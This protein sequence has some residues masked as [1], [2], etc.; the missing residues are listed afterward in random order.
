MGG[1]FNTKDNQ[2]HTLLTALISQFPSLSQIK[3]GT[4]TVE[5]AK[6][7]FAIQLKILDFLLVNNTDPNLGGAHFEQPPLTFLIAE[8]D[9]SYL[10]QPVVSI[11]KRFLDWNADVNKADQKG[12]RALHLAAWT[13]D[14]LA[15]K[16]LLANAAKINATCAKKWTAL[17]YAAARGHVEIVKML[18]QNGAD[19]RCINKEGDTALQLA[20]R[21]NTEPKFLEVEKSIA[22]YI[23]LTKGKTLPPLPE[24]THVYLDNPIV[25]YPNE[26]CVYH[27]RDPHNPSNETRLT[28]VGDAQD[29]EFYDISSSSYKKVNTPPDELVSYGSDTCCFIV[30][31]ALP[32]SL[33][34]K[35]F[36]PLFVYLYQTPG[37]IYASPA[38]EINLYGQYSFSFETQK[39]IKVLDDSTVGNYKQWTADVPISFGQYPIFLDDEKPS[40]DALRSIFQQFLKHNSLDKLKCQLET[41]VDRCQ[42][43]AFFASEF[44]K[45]NYGLSTK[46]AF[47]LWENSDWNAFYGHKQWGY[48]CAAMVDEWVFDPWLGS[49][50]GWTRLDQWLFR[51]EEPKPRRLLLT[52]PA[53]FSDLVYGRRADGLNLME[54]DPLI[55]ADLFKD[56]QFLCSEALPKDQETPLHSFLRPLQVSLVSEPPKV[57]Q[58]S[59]T[60]KLPMASLVFSFFTTKEKGRVAA[61]S[62]EF[63]QLA[64]GLADWNT[65]L[66]KEF[67]NVNDAQKAKDLFLSQPSSRLPEYLFY[68][69]VGRDYLEHHLLPNGADKGSKKERVE[70]LK[71]MHLKGVFEQ[72]LLAMDGLLNLGQFDLWVINERLLNEFGLYALRKGFVQSDDYLSGG[73]NIQ[74]IAYS[75]KLFTED[76]I[77]ALE[78]GLISLKGF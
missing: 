70:L 48:H 21:R 74:K 4:I 8:K 73:L 30:K 43:R 72:N 23:T 27:I 28:F 11:L 76:G 38:F 14:S 49:N 46:L 17:H 2:G 44:L 47:K 62:K 6:K 52:H 75:K 57:S 56:L 77:K 36:P 20:S 59:K 29:Y 60:H 65:G 1:T 58:S 9:L 68:D 19:H 33:H 71:T 7:K 22:A 34:T 66:K 54:R 37:K 61:V 41:T 42:N 25:Y 53:V 50:Q 18:L 45:H 39:N 55:H 16:F 31:D 13:N 69:K 3:A 64:N 10:D 63:K 32:K 26:N 12:L 51:S 5:S 78:A 15:T 35:G 67:K 24:T 40:M